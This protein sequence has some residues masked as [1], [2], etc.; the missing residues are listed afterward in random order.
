MLPIFVLAGISILLA[1]ML[2]KWGAPW[3]AGAPLAG[4][5][6]ITLFEFIGIYLIGE[7]ERFLYVAIVVGAIYATGLALIPYVGRFLFRRWTRL[8][9]RE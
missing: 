5:L 7:E 8:S 3:F 2:M 4:I 6:A 1:S 9:N